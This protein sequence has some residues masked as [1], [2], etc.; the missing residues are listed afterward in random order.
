MVDAPQGLALTNPLDE[1]F[2]SRPPLRM[3]RDRFLS[4]SVNPDCDASPGRY[5]YGRTVIPMRV[6]AIAYPNFS[7]LIVIST[8][9]ALATDAGATYVN[10]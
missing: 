1:R 3:K 7:A 6:V 2:S 4:L 10:R 9:V 8:F 5:P